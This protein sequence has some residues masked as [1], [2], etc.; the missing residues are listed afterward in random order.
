M[1][2]QS[3]I[4]NFLQAPG[5][6][7]R[8]H[9]LFLIAFIPL[10]LSMPFWSFGSYAEIP[11]SIIYGFGIGIIIAI[12]VFVCFNVSCL[13]PRYLPKGEYFTYIVVLLLLTA[14]FISLKY[15]AE[16]LILLN[17]G[18]KRAMNGVTVLEWLSN[19]MLYTITIASTSIT[20]L[21][22]QWMTD[23]AR[24][25]N[26]ENK[27]LKNHIE[28]FKSRINHQFLYATLDYASEKAKSDPVQTSETLFNLSE[29]LSYQLYDN[30][31]DS[32]LL[33]SDIEFIRNFLM[34]ERQNSGHRLTFTISATGRIN[35]FIPPNLFTPLIE[36]A[37]RQQPDELRI[38]F[39]VDDELIRFE[40]ITPNVRL[41]STDFKK[42][43]QRLELLH[44]NKIILNKKAAIIEL[45]FRIC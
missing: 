28:E 13:A 18:V 42:I 11:L 39:D 41:S 45:Q 29:L 14:G 6:R 10:G 7:T 32:V 24:I 26:L 30:R 19:L 21:F 12:M 16:D 9:I 15:I 40:C 37:L 25:E 34:L 36:I 35:I 2:Q 1:N 23:N 44:G 3:F 38:R 5:F 33:E 8:R 22:K 20:V 31:R 4:Y 43:T 17:F 27:Q